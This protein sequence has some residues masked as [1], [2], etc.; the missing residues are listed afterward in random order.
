MNI[1]DFT[2]VD[3][4]E[5]RVCDIPFLLPSKYII[6]KPIGKGAY[7]LV[8]EAYDKELGQKVAIKKSRNVFP[9]TSRRPLM[10][11]RSAVT[12]AKVSAPNEPLSEEDDNA[13]LRAPR[14]LR[15]IKLLIHLEQHPNI[16][17]LKDVILPKDFDSFQ[18][19]YFVMDLMPADLRDLLRLGQQLP[20]AHIQFI[21]YQL[22]MAVSYMHS[23][24][25]I[26]RDIKPEN[27]LVNQQCGLKLCDF[28]ITRGVDFKRDPHISSIYVQ[29]R[30]YR[31]PELLLEFDKVSPAIDMWSCGCVLAE[32]LQKGIL[33]P[34]KFPAHQVEL[35]LKVLGTPDDITKVK[36]SEHGIAFLSKLKKYQPKNLKTLFPGVNPLALDLLS[37]MLVW[38][39]ENR[40]TAIEAMRHP[41]LADLYSSEDEYTVA[42]KFDFE[43][44]ARMTNMLAVKEEAFRTILEYNGVLVRRRSSIALTSGGADQKD[45]TA[46]LLRGFSSDNSIIPEEHVNILAKFKEMLTSHSL[47]EKDRCN[48]DQV[49]EDANNSALLVSM[50]AIA[51]KFLENLKK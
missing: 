39:P 16:V 41:Y 18:D 45:Q 33:F 49:H 5:T 9:V 7:G 3:L 48:V 47:R 13:L 30:W 14:L 42:T 51:T 22:M 10:S 32:L 28:G 46:M 8:V 26:H 40:I 38:E 20:D 44:E 31:A 17:E 27:I 24:D 43:Y 23:A 36:G 2:A 37:R 6:D 34:G 21:M 25:I 15:E 1:L 4:Q 12:Q 50:G 29:T 19:I 35:I 11:R